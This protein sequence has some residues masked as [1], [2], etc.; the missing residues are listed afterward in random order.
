MGSCHRS[1]RRICSKKGEDI[2]IVKNRERRN[3]RIC[4]ISVEEEVY[5]TIKITTNV[6]SVLCAKERWEEEDSARLQ[7]SEQLDNQEQLFI[8]TNLK[9]NR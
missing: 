1:Q 5:L 4:K 2:S 6:T 9:L 8:T 7:I 3:L